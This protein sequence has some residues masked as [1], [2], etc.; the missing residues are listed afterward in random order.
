MR[1]FEQRLTGGHPNSLGNTVEIVDEILANQELFDE[2]FNCYFS[3]DEIVR[4]RVS[5]TMKRI[6][7]EKSEYLL[8]YLDR[9]LNEIALINQPSTKWTL[10]LLFEMLDKHFSEEQLEKAKSIIKHNLETESDWIVLNNSM[11][12]LAKWGKSDIELMGWL[13]PNL[14]RLTQDERKS[15]AKRASKILDSVN[16]R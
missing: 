6:C 16:K 1:N 7:K 2:L 10:A 12:T 5:N 11:E 13:I 8:P 15:V 3:Q 4:L 9:F 14:K